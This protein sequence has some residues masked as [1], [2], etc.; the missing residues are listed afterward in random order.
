M[1]RFRRSKMRSVGKALLGRFTGATPVTLF[2]VQGASRV[3]LRP[4]TLAALREGGKPFDVEVAADGTVAPRDVAERTFLG[5]NGMSMRPSGITMGM[6]VG[7][8]RAKHARVYEV[9]AGTPIPPELVLLHEHSD[10]YSLQP[11]EPML[12]PALEARL[13]AFLTQSGVVCYPNKVA[14]YNARPEMSP[15]SVGCD[16]AY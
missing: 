6:L 5:P 4:G 9:P 14:F 12:L 3:K 7:V 10:H 1:V 11:A 13:T 15:D 16:D 2:R 8:F